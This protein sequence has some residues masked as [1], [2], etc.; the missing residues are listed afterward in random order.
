MEKEKNASSPSGVNINKIQPANRWYGNL[1]YLLVGILFGIVFVK[2]EIISWFRIQE[3]FR[4]QSF[5]MYGVIGSA[6]LTGMV[7]VFIIK[8]FNIKTL[9]GEKIFIAPKTFNKGQIYGGLIFGFG[10]AVTGACPGPLFAQIGT[11]AFA[12]IITLVSAVAGTWVY[13]YFREKLPH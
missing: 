12:V 1:K 10:W 5:H 6:V 9:S 3:M 11:G 7:S 8:K 13:G 2:A 4:L